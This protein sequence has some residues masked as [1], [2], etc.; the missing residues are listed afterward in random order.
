M[1]RDRRQAGAVNAAAY[2]GEAGITECAGYVRVDFGSCNAAELAAL[3]RGFA[4]F[5]L[6]NKVTRA[7]LKAGDNDPR[8]H[9]RLRDA[10]MT[11]AHLAEIPAEFKLA[12]IPSTQAIEIVYREAQRHLRAAGLN[13]WVFDTENEAVDWLE[14]RQQGGRAAS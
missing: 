5:C 2:A 1:L 12:L 7:L 9:Y 4:A 10:L 8:G 6:D 3:Y 13:A 14:G 11:M